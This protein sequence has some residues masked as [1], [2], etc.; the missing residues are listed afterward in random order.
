M[1]ILDQLWVQMS[2]LLA[3]M[4]MVAMMIITLTLGFFRSH[5]DVRFQ[6]HVPRVR[7]TNKVP[8]ALLRLCG[9]LVT[10]LQTYIFP[11]AFPFSIPGVAGDRLVCPPLCTNLLVI[12]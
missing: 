7:R 8:A 3:R 9:S 5:S 11:T 2:F 1:F 12:Y 6:Y 4:I 10:V